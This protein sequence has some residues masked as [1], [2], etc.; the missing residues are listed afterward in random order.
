MKQEKMRLFVALLAVLAPA[1][2]AWAGDDDEKKKE[3]KP[4]L[5]KFKEVTKDM[6]VKEGYWTLYHNEKEGKL[7]ARWD[8]PNN[9]GEGQGAHA[10]WVD[11]HGDIY[12]NQNLEGH[13]LL[14]YRKVA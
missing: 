8:K 11:S 6:T 1:L 3:D 12:V 13:R 7:L 9:A 10:V 4:D 14:K 5:P 2:C